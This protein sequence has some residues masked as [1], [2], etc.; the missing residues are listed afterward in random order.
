MGEHGQGKQED[1]ARGEL[2][3]DPG[4]LEDETAAELAV[5][6]TEGEDGAEAKKEV[7]Q[8]AVAFGEGVV[9]RVEANGRVR[10]REELDV[11]RFLERLVEGAVV[12]G[13]VGEE[14]GR[15]SCRERVS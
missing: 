3:D 10:L 4:F 7:V 2:D 1:V 15:A 12:G 8:V 6:V 14:I 5:E 9:A 11:A 13:H